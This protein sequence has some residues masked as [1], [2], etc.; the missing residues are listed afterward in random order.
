LTRLIAALVLLAEGTVRSD[1]QR[2]HFLDGLRGV[3]IGM[4]V[5]YHAYLLLEPRYPELQHWIVNRYGLMGVELFFMISGFVILLTLERCSSFSQFF[6]R[7][8][9]RLWP[10]ML[11]AC[12]FTLA[13]FAVTKSWP[14]HVSVFPGLTLIDDRW[15]SWVF[16]RPVNSLD[17]A[18]WTLYL[19]MRFYLIFGITYFLWGERRAIAVLVAMSL[20]Y[21]VLLSLDMGM[22]AFRWTD[23]HYEAWF[24]S[25][26]LFYLWSKEREP[27]LFYQALAAGALAAWIYYP[28]PGPRL[29]G[30]ALV[31]LFALAV[32]YRF[33]QTLLSTRTLSW[34]GAI[35]YPLYLVHTRILEAFQFVLPID[36]PLLIPIPGI[37]FSLGVAHLI[38]RHAEPWIRARII[39]LISLRGDIK[40]ASPVR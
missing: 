27:T 9:L 38:T 7:R 26:A 23:M 18:Y 17:G 36:N 11:V 22:G 12:V 8:W 14:P 13:L 3:A 39:D 30:L 15:Y 25:G 24:A 20:F 10:A 5:L 4:V 21:L 37:V 19:E 16:G 33:M 31:T 6:K 34:L 1:I 35:S 2:I 29:F 32:R 28:S 40:A